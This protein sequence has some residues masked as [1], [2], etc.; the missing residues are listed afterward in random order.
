MDEWMD[1][2]KDGWMDVPG[3]VCYKIPYVTYLLLIPCEQHET[4]H[5][6]HIHYD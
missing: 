3:S 2:W 4:S 5:Y 1:G 6:I